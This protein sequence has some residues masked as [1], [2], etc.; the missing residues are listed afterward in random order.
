VVPKSKGTNLLHMRTY[1]QRTHGAAAWQRVLSSLPEG[2]RAIVSAASPTGWYDLGAQHR[3]LRCIDRVVGKGDL[4]LVPQIGRFEADEDLS[5][6]HRLFVRL[7]SPGYVLEKAGEYWRRFY[8]TGK[9]DVV[10]GDNTATGRLVDFGMVDDAFCAY[11]AAY[12]YRMFHL[13]G[14][15]TGSLEHTEC[16]AL[17]GRACVFVGRW[18]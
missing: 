7:T 1:V 6:I 18:T 8:D 14:A 12:I 9:W 15:R 17:G 16:R 11:L 13:A 2:D 4:A 10:R 3:L 5:T